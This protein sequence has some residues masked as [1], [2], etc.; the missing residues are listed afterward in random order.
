M[1]NDQEH[2]VEKATRMATRLNVEVELVAPAEDLLSTPIALPVMERA[3]AD[4][5]PGPGS[6]RR[7]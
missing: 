5:E 4:E 2:A 6:D 1:A 3:A 7:E